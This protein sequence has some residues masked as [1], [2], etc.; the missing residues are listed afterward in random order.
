[1][2]G[3]TV[4]TRMASLPVFLG[5]IPIVDVSCDISVRWADALAADIFKTL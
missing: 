5:D 1:M 2:G 3:G 4:V